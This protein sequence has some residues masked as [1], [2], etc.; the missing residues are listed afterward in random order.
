MT[1]CIAIIDPATETYWIIDATPDFREQLHLLQSNYADYSFGGIFL[2]HAHVGHYTGLIHLGR[3]VMGSKTIPVYT[4][5]RMSH[6]LKNNG[7]WSQLVT[8][9]NIDLVPI[10]S[11]STIELNNKLVITPLLVPHRDE[12][13]ETVGYKVSGVSASLLFIPDIDK[14]NK[15]DRNILDEIQSVDHALLDGTFYQNGE[16]PGRDMALIPH[17]F[18]EESLQLFDQMDKADRAKVKFIHFNHTN[19][20]LDPSSVAYKTII[21]NGFS[22]AY[23]GE[24]LPL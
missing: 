16:I 14:W 20:V 18:I 5:P 11:D 9:N 6:F 23:E 24:K 15:W 8:L 4:M 21:N 12:F 10:L 22:I 13:S 1:S 19:P 17:P 7:P 2:T 3:E